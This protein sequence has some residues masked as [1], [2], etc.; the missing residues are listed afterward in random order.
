[1][2]VRK[3]TATLTYS[4]ILALL[5]GFAGSATAQ[6]PSWDAY[7]DGTKPAQDQHV[8]YRDLF[9]SK[10]YEEAFPMWEKLYKHVKLPLPAKTTHFM[11]G[12]TM[13]KEFAK[14]EKDRAKKAEYVEKMMQLYED[15]AECLG[16][17]ATDRA[18]E[19]YNIYFVRGN[20][21]KAIEQFER[22]LEL[23]KNETPAIVMLP[24]SQLTVYL[25]TKKHPKYNAEY[26]RN[27]YKQ[28]EGLK[29]YNVENKTAKAADYEKRWVKVDAEFKKIGG[30]IWGC[31]FYTDEWTPKFKADPMN[32]EQNAEIVKIIK[33]KCGTDNE[34]Y[35]AV[36]AV[37]GPWKDSMDYVE[38]EKQFDALCNLKKGKFREQGSLK[39]A[40]A[41][42]NA[43]SARLLEEAYEWYEKSLDDP[44]SEDCE[45]T[46]EEKGKLAYR[47]AY[48]KYR[49]GAYSAARSLCYK[50]ASFKKGWGDPYMLIG[51]MYASSGKRCS[52]GVG[53]GWDAQVV[54]WAAMDMWAKAKSVDP[55]ISSKANSQIAKYRKYL[56]TAS[57]VFQRSLKVGG[58]YKVGCWINA[59]TTIRTNGE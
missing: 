44:S 9:K 53:T 50:A 41:G 12:I 18:W 19:G 27:L 4:W 23:G 43:E 20:S 24:I 14:A 35:N 48:E 58:T 25:F 17:N 57:D 42:D 28:L 26:M 8:M 5:V 11:D 21:E 46:N 49:K 55:S 40:K 15:M 13:Y 31:E 56:P 2:L 1:M 33:E 10:K 30:A 52:G 47:I 3:W 38:A 22:S 16:E 54:T 37:Y 59:T 6:C 29:N 51:N 39:A 45:T 34:F 32:M 36:W 7:P